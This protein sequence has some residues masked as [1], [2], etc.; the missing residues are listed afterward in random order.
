MK[1]KLFGFA[2]A[3]VL[4]A[5]SQSH[6]TTIYEFDTSVS[7]TIA[8]AGT[9]DLSVNGSTATF[10]VSLPSSYSFTQ[11]AFNLLPGATVTSS[12]GYSIITNANANFKKSAFTPNYGPFNTELNATSSFGNSLTFTVS[13]FAGISDVMV[14]GSPI[15]FIASFVYSGN[16][17]GVMASDADYVQ[18]DISETP[19]PATLP[20]FV[21]G[22]GTLGLL[23]LRG[24]RKA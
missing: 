2:T 23:R 10:T 18:N 8:P 7:G 13:N 16:T 17:S 4:F 15:W 9:V 5:A 6:A 12:D 24:L 22:L 19:L 11:F 1:T 3:L 14:S 21:A 20:L